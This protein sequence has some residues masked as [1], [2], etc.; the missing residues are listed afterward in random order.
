MPCRLQAAGFQQGRVPRRPPNAATVAR[1]RSGGQAT[2]ERKS[3]RWQAVPPPPACDAADIRSASGALSS[4]ATFSR[5]S[6]LRQESSR[7]IHV[8]AIAVAEARE[9]PFFFPRRAQH[10]QSDGKRSDDEEEPV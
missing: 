6:D 5:S 1:L 8:R 2:V 7:S 10:Q 4:L 9:E 3:S